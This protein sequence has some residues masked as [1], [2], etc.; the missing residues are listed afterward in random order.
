MTWLVFTGLALEFCAVLWG[1]AFA[2]NAGL[3]R[4]MS[5]RNAA[6]IGIWIFAVGILFQVWY[7]IYLLQDNRIG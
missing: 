6:M 4:Q 3:H 2:T 1:T 7:H 5:A